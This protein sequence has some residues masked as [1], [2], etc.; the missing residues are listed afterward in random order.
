MPELLQAFWEG[1][2]KKEGHEGG[3]DR[4]ISRVPRA[5]RGDT[6]QRLTSG[7]IYSSI[8][9]VKKHR[10]EEEKGEGRGRGKEGEGRGETTRNAAVHPHPALVEHP[11]WPKQPKTRQPTL[12][13]TCTLKTSSSSNPE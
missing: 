8:P 6:R 13:R 4:N 7:F 1:G 12:K 5:L 9:E 10:R 11:R 2:K 3:D